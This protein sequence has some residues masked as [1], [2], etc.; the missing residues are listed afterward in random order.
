MLWI[1]SKKRALGCTIRDKSSTGAKLEVVPDKYGDGISELAVGTKVSLSFDA[2]QDRTSV[3]CEVMWIS[4][5]R[6]GVRFA[7]QFQTQIN[8]PK[9]GTKNPDAQAAIQL[10]SSDGARRRPFSRT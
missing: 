5:S 6:C 4:E 3:R 1:E 7:G 9:K 2:G 8:N 10:V